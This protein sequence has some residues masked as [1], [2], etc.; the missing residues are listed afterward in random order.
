MFGLKRISKGTYLTALFFLILS[1]FLILVWFKDGHFYGGGDVGLPT[2]NPMRIFQIASYIWWEAI[3][4]GFLIPHVIT[5]ITLY[6]FLSFLQFFGLGPVGIQ[7]ILFF[8]LLFLMGFGMYL[9]TI[10]IIGK[11]KKI[12]ALLAGLFYIFNPYM[13]LQIWHRFTHTSMFFVAAL[14]FLVL[15]WK[16]WIKKGNSLFLLL[17]LLTNLIASYM[18]GTL[19]YVF[20]FWLMMFLL[21]ISEVFLPWENK[22]YFIEVLGRVILGLV[23]WVLFNSWWLIPVLTVSQGVASQQHSIWESIA[24]LIIISKQAVLPYSLQMVNSFY[25]FAQ[26]ELGDIYKSFFFR[27]IPWIG[28]ITIFY[29]ILSALRKKHLAAYVLIY[30]VVIMLAKG[31]SPPFGEPFL[32]LFSKSFVFGLL[33]NPFE[34]I[35]IL[36]PLISS[37]LFVVGVEGF[38]SRF[39][40]NLG[41]RLVLVALLVVMGI[42]YFPMYQGT[43]LGRIGQPNYVDVPQSYEEADRWLNQKV[44]QDSIVD[45]K[46]L[47]L[48]L[49]R[50]DIATYKWEY[51]YHGIESSA[52]IFSSLPSISHGLNL[53]RIDDSLTALLLIFHKPYNLHQ[54]KILRLLQD[55]N[56][57]F[58]ILHKDIEWRGTDMYD[59]QE[60]EKVLDT[61]PF[62]ERKKQFGELVIYEILPEYFRPKVVLSNAVNFV[63]P[64]QAV[65]RMW[66]YLISENLYDYI[67]PL[68][69]NDVNNIVAKSDEAIIFPSRSFSYLEASENG[70]D[71]VA[72]NLV[73]LLYGLTNTK[74]FA[75]KD[76]EIDV[77]KL[78]SQV[79]SSGEDL[80]NTYLSM[81]NS[82]FLQIDP[83][84]RRYSQTIDEL[85]KRDL[86]KPKLSFYVSPSMVND[87]F[88]L[89]LL[90]LDQMVTKLN[91]DQQ[92]IINSARNKIKQDLTNQKLLPIYPLTKKNNLIIQE[93]Q[94][95]QFRIP[96][97]GKYELL[98]T[99]PRSLDIYPNKLASLDFQINDQTV[100]LKS[101]NKGDLSSFGEVALN[102]G[103]QEFS[104]NNLLSEN[105]FPSFNNLVKT[106][107]VKLIDQN[108]IQLSSDGILPAFA[109]SQ[110]DKIEGEEVYQVSFEALI[111]TGIGFYLQIIQDT[112]PVENGKPRPAVNAAIYRAQGNSKWQPYILKLQALNLTTRQALFRLIVDPRGTTSFSTTVDNKP[113]LISIKNLKIQRIL[114]N[115]FYLFSKSQTQNI[116]TASEVIKLEQK[117]PV[118]YTGKI[119]IDQPTFLIFKEAFHSGWELELKKDNKVIKIDQHYIAN[120]YGNA[121]WVEETGEYNFKIEFKPQRKVTLGIY[122]ALTGLLIVFILMFISK[123]KQKYGHS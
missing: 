120:L 96:L 94:I 103:L 74:I 114:N 20:P 106:G 104:F 8:A 40:K 30:F 1:F 46:I 24:T 50:S 123:Y 53:Q 65:M 90:M 110:L 26:A 41:T 52:T 6:F 11:D 69:D 72:N 28:V 116:N 59:P 112:D 87:V 81:K 63:Y 109:D 83:L 97:K 67:T 88:K 10:S 27:L 19:A 64:E 93:R 77:T 55:F 51:G 95:N 9:L 105:L 31:T 37:I 38:F 76:G 73:L 29:G 121:W 66:S 22:T 4:P 3:A 118:L 21:A 102:E 113:A 48:P 58:I 75:N 111:Q 13:M 62:L 119:K 86:R 108:T 92:D 98:M 107:D 17:F 44:H 60:T 101:I 45:G 23:I 78:I 85:F 56:V 43:I 84:I 36:L 7:A 71:Y 35:G 68:N 122:L 14:P 49:T 15:F 99:N 80:V 82:N 91:P 16:H 117:T 5:S 54:D 34:K 2:Y 47:H 18:F 70:L 57:R 25:L 32:L 12:Y 33:R 115:P 89:H 79:I 42:Y 39:G 100:S 61:L